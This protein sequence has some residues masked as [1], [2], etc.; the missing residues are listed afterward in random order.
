M[1]TIPADR[2]EHVVWCAGA[3]VFAL[4]RVSVDAIERPLVLQETQ[5]ASV[6]AGLWKHP[7]NVRSH[8]A[9]G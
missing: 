9:L 6:E 8:W 2:H 4:Q 3:A 7:S 5:T 1:T